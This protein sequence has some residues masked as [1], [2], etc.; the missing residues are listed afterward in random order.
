MRKASEM[1][2]AQ[3]KDKRRA[4]EA[5]PEF[6]KNTM[7]FDKDESYVKMRES[8]SVAEKIAFAEPIKD[9]GNDLFAKGKY[10]QAMAKYTAAVA[11]FRYWNRTHHGNE[12]NIV[13]HYDDEALSGDERTAAHGLIRSIYLNAAQCM[14]KGNMADGSREIIWTCTEVLE[15]DPDSAKA[16]YRRAMAHAEGDTSH[17][18][19]LAVRDLTRAN[20]L[21][22]NDATIRHAL[23]VH[24]SSHVTQRAKDK[25]AYGGVFNSR[26]GLYS[27]AERSGGAV[28]T[29]D[30]SQGKSEGNQT[31]EDGDPALTAFRNMSEQELK[32]RCKAIGVDLDNP[33][34]QREL[35]NRAKA[36]K[37]E[38]LKAKAREMGID[39]GD[40]AV[41]KMLELL[42]KEDRGKEDLAKLPAWRRWIYHSFDGTKRFNVQNLMYIALAVSRRLFVCLFRFVC[43]SH[44]KK[45][46]ASTW[47]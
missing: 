13:K 3:M 10:A 8:A 47:H 14:K 33:R 23:H 42:E 45:Y 17:T 27:A 40:P 30:S 11:V 1:K 18:L 12:Q 36:R 16:Y 43:F 15:I 9:E 37:E 24:R 4:W 39:L 29:H 19:E 2:A 31:N 6:M 32:A 44:Y 5:S 7:T 41:R 34:V 26:D 38:E 22:P 20:L 46:I 28:G 21:A 35:A 25:A